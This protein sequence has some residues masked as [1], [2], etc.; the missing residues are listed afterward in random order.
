MQ[1]YQAQFNQ[2]IDLYQKDKLHSAL[3]ICGAEGSYVDDFC[4]DLACKILNFDVSKEFCPDIKIVNYDNSKAKKQIAV[5]EIRSI[6][7]F[8]HQTSYCGGPKFVIINSANH[9]NNSS[10]NAL[11]KI[12]EEPP[13][14]SY[15]L[16]VC[17]NKDNLIDTIKSRTISIQLPILDADDTEKLLSQKLFDVDPIS[18]KQA[19]AIYPG[20]IE[21]AEK[22]IDLDLAEIFQQIEHLNS[23]THALDI[24]E[25]LTKVDL[26]DDF[27]FNSLTKIIYHLCH[28]KLLPQKSEADMFAGLSEEKTNQLLSEELVKFIDN[29]TTNLNE[30]KIYNLDKVNFLRIYLSQFR[31]L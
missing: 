30:L 3:L 26:K 14:N 6:N 21:L 15:F 23:N 18:I 20:S 5:D 8:M 25:I 11:L 13:I 4:R 19:A 10:A 12:L 16:L 9:L 31:K 24:E 28:Q 1:Y 27:V 29:F 7:S 22:Y 17:H 2:L